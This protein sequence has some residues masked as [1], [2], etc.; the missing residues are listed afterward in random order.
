MIEQTIKEYAANL[1]SRHIPVVTV[2]KTWDEEDDVTLTCVRIDPSN[3]PTRF[4]VATTGWRTVEWQDISYQYDLRS[5]NR[6]RP[7]A[8]RVPYLASQHYGDDSYTVSHLCH[9]EW[10]HNPLHT[11]LE[12]LADNKGRNG[13]PGGRACH[14]LMPCIIPGPQ[15]QGLSSETFDHSLVAQLF[16]L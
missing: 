8:Y 9:N 15:Y 16:R 1:Y 7:K 5:L 3:L 10:C 12:S 2:V 13:C 14:H 11:V 4:R 6:T